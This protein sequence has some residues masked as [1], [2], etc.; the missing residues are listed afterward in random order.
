MAVFPSG[1]TGLQNGSDGESLRAQQ[2]F[3][4]ASFPDARAARNEAQHARQRVRES[5]WAGGRG[6]GFARG[7]RAR[8][9]REAAAAAAALNHTRAGPRRA[10]AGAATPR[11]RRALPRQARAPD[12]T[13]RYALPIA[14]SAAG[15]ATHNGWRYVDWP[16]RRDPG[17]GPSLRGKRNGQLPGPAEKPATASEAAA[18]TAALPLEVHDAAVKARRLPVASGVPERPPFVHLS[19]NIPPMDALRRFV[20]NNFAPRL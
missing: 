5:R 15:H 6:Q 10:C 4:D 3:L 16:L 19:S 7:R 14:R 9:W 11:E 18:I 20:H 2:F 8:P 12:I 1:F 13:H 17:H